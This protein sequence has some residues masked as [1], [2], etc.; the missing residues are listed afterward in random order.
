MCTFR[1]GSSSLVQIDQSPPVY[2]LE[3]PVRHGHEAALTRGLVMRGPRCSRPPQPAPPGSLEPWSLPLQQSSLSSSDSTPPFPRSLSASSVLLKTFF[4]APLPLF[5]HLPFFLPLPS[6]LLLF[7]LLPPAHPFS[8]HLSPSFLL[9]SH[10]NSP[11]TYLQDTHPQGT[12]TVP[13]PS[14]PPQQF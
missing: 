14:Q 11:L 13:P 5:P 8:S 2:S 7:S 4:C 12:R 6:P 3:T 9:S 10:S 1:F